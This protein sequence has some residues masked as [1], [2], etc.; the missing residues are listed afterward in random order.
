MTQLGILGIDSVDV[1]TERQISERDARNAGFTSTKDLLDSLPNTSLDIYR[2]SVSFVG[3]DPRIEL[4]KNANISDSELFNIIKKLGQMDERSS[5]GAW[6]RKYL[7]LIRDRPNTRAADLAESIG[8]ETA[9]FK[10]RIRKL[11]AIGL[12][13]SLEVGYRLSPRG[14]KILDAPKWKDDG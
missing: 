2:I 3:E 5:S 9:K 13:E 7:E 6:T 4:R 10:S 8:T 14:K 1:V 11:K 12:T